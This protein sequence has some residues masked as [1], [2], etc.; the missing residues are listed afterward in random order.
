MA[1]GLLAAVQAPAEA[2]SVNDPNEPIT[3][4]DLR[5]A[6][7]LQISA[8]ELQVRL[9]FWGRTPMWMLRRHA[10]RVEMSFDAPK[11]AHEALGFRFWPNRRGQLRI[12]WGEPAS[13]CCARHGAQHPD[14]FT[15]LAVIPFS[16]DG[17]IP[18]IQSFRAVRT[19]R[20]QPCWHVIC[21]VAGGKIVDKTAWVAP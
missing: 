12:T 1:T 7:V 14:P 8:D 2:A 4:L 16:L 13:D 5:S 17:A 3:R 11:N 6:S 19:A 15:Y 10:A 20:L 9:V 18:P 21:G